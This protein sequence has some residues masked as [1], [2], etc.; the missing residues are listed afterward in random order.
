MI[1]RLPLLAALVLA[2]VALL[3]QS[4]TSPIP[5]TSLAEQRAA[6]VRAKAQAED[7]RKR[8]EALEARA[9]QSA[10]AADKTRNQIAALAARIQQS[11]ADLRAGEARIGIIAALQ[12]EQ[13][14][15]LA[16]RQKPIVRL[17][18]ALQQ[19]ARRSPVL[20]LVEPGSVSDAVHR[21]IVLA[22]VM[23]IV[24][25]NT[26][27]LR[28]EIEQSGELRQSADAAR[29]ALAKSRDGL[30]TYQR[31]LAN[32]EQRQRVTSRSLRE[33]A[34]LETE[35]SLAMGEE[36]RDITDLMAQIEDAAVIR[37]ALIR[38]PGP[39]PRPA[40]PGD[41][42]LP[43]DRAAAA[44]SSAAPA[45]RLPVI[46]DV[47]TGFGEISESG[48]RARGLTIATA[49]AAT[50]VAPA[51]G[52]VAF[53]G[54]FRGYGNIVIIEHGGGWTTLIAQLGR[55]SAQIGD[56]LRQGD[57]IGSTGPGKPRLIVELRRQERPVD[58]GALIR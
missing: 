20:T 6:L 36:A 50:V 51:A 18:A 44:Q 9:R 55:L 29:L 57:P 13:A 39:V 11:E 26:R 3:A 54:P 41:A 46:G 42:P 15:R 4:A 32:L 10:A 58:I 31:T 35:R 5:G 14:R 19:I 30:A 1:P 48:V 47:I 56:Q 40:A 37:D 17:T 24:M 53:A 49:P 27:G 21:R 33:S 16:L 8:S 25:A 28:K 12:R 7:A 45:Y 38:L 34:S 22:R 23:P 2:P 43:V 52:R